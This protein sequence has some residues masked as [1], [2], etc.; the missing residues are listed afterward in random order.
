MIHKSDVKKLHTKVT[1]K[2]G[3]VSPIASSSK[4]IYKQ[5]LFVF[6]VVLHIRTHKKDSVSPVC[7]IFSLHTPMQ[8]NINK[9]VDNHKIHIQKHY[10]VFLDPD[11]PMLHAGRDPGGR[12]LPRLSRLSVSGH[13]KG[14]PGCWRGHLALTPLPL[15][16][17][18]T[19]TLT[20]S[21]QP[22]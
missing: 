5:F 1:S 13:H 14:P 8:K 19:A 18:P 6:H 12:S 9:L 20:D 11:L 17:R 15:S 4:K 10:S 3:M 22:V 2:R 21:H 16:N 7:R